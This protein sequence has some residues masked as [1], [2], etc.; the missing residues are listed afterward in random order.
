MK[1]KL[2]AAQW[3]GAGI[4]SDGNTHSCRGARGHITEGSDAYRGGIYID[5]D[6]NKAKREYKLFDDGS[7]RNRIESSH[8]TPRIRFMMSPVIRIGAVAMDDNM[9]HF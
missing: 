4:N 3:G 8:C 5:A 6:S 1:G 2:V 9:C 7:T